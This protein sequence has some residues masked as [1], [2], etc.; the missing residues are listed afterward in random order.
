VG[1]ETALYSNLAKRT[2]FDI[3]QLVT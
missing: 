2:V 3:H 1:I